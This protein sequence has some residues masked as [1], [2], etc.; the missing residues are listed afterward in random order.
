MRVV[1]MAPALSAIEEEAGGLSLQGFPMTSCFVDELPLEITIPVVVAV[2][3]LSGDEY[4]PALYLTA[5]SP[6]GERVSTMEFRW[7]WPDYDDVPVK[8]R[9]FVQYLPL[10]LQ[11][12]GTHLLSLRH[13]PDGEPTADFP[14]PVYLNPGA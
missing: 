9:A 10:Y 2:C 5:D 12:E 11:S 14:L 4:A 8:Y 13:S 6:T 7:Q 3:A 1:T